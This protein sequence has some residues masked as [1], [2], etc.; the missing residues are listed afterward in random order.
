MIA[1]HN[2]NSREDSYPSIKPVLMALNLHRFSR[3]HG[4]GL[5]QKD[6]RTGIEF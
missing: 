3:E 2:S 1:F 5:Q 4:K 6:F